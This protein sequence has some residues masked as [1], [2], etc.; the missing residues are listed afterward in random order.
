VDESH[1]QPNPQD[2]SDNWG[3][4]EHPS[5]EIKSTRECGGVT[6]TMSVNSLFKRTKK[7]SLIPGRKW[8]GSIKR[9]TAKGHLLKEAGA[10]A[11]STQGVQKG[12]VGGGQ[13]LVVGP[14][15]GSGRTRPRV[16]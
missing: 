13:G 12:T 6:Q 1:E 7:S 2:Q 14:L 8:R 10:L 16:T 9:A 5:K 3:C 15:Q 4:V 11:A